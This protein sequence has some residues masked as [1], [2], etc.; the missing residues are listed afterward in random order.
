MRAHRLDLYVHPATAEIRY[1]LVRLRCT[2]LF[3]PF[4]VQMDL[5]F[6]L[7]A[8]L[9]FAPSSH[10]SEGYD[11]CDFPTSIDDCSRDNTHDASR[12][13]AVDERSLRIGECIP[14]S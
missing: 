9:A 12:S 10:H 3:P 14:Q 2:Y 5:H 8:F 1:A 4:L 6:R 7:C 13:A 11:T